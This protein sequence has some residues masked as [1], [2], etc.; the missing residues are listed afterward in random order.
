MTTYFVLPFDDHSSAHVG[1]SIA[2]L[3]QQGVPAY[4]IETPPS[5]FVVFNGTTTDL[6]NCLGFGEGEI[7]GIV[8]SIKWYQGF[9]PRELW[10]WLDMHRTNG[11]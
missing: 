4:P 8:L 10:E 3:R 2:E 6:S 9:A 7:S 5:W 1:A 11:Q